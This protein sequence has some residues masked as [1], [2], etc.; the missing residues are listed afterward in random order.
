L[1]RNIQ[2]RTLIVH[3]SKD[4]VVIPINAFVLEHHLPDAQLVM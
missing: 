2:Q 4:V 1:L 3:G